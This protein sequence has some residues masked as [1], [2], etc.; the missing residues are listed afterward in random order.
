MKETQESG[1]TRPLAE[2]TASQNSA[3][4]WSLYKGRKDR[5]SKFQGYA[6]GLLAVVLFLLVLVGLWIVAV[7]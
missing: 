4:L 6:F 2:E 7:R 3:E 1:S 5:V